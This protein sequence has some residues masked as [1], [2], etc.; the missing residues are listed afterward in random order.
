MLSQKKPL[1]FLCIAPVV[2]A[3]A[4]GKGVRVTIG[5]DE[6]T[7][8]AVNSMGAKHINCSAV[9]F[10]EDENFKVYSTPSYMLASNTSEIDIGVGKMIT[11]MLK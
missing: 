6:V 11:A 8:D 10:V 9:D 7:A 4:I 1:G 2:A 5:T 3:K